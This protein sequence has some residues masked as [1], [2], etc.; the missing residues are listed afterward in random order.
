MTI[1][2][3]ETLFQTNLKPNKKLS[4]EDLSTGMIVWNETQREYQRIR[5]ISTHDLADYHFCD[6]WGNNIE[7]DDLYNYK[8]E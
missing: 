3:Y 5:Y 2:Q 8:L 1:S 4:L 7:K 6:G